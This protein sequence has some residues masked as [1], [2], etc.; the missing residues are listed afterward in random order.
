VPCR[1][2]ERCRT[3]ADYDEVPCF[4]RSNAGVLTMKAP[5]G[6]RVSTPAS[7]QHDSFHHRLGFHARWPRGPQRRAQL[8]LAVVFGFDT[9][10]MWRAGSQVENSE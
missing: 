8:L 2:K 7:A 3:A 5:P 9:C 6:E 4:T 10:I 1:Y